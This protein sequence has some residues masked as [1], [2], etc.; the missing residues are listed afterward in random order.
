MTSRFSSATCRIEARKAGKFLYQDHLIAFTMSLIFATPLMLSCCS[1]LFICDPSL[2]SFSIITV[3]HGLLSAT[4]NIPAV[5]LLAYRQAEG[6]GRKD[7]EVV[8]RFFCDVLLGLCERLTAHAVG[9]LALLLCV[10][11]RKPCPLLFPTSPSNVGMVPSPNVVLEYISIEC[12]RT[13]IR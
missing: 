10:S 12:L 5:V 7:W 8:M 13:P 6:H 1:S 9:G 3:F 11:S 4:S 2:S